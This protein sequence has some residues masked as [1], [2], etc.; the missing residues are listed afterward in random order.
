MLHPNYVPHQDIWLKTREYLRRPRENYG[1]DGYV[2][3]VWTWMTDE[4]PQM[5][6][7]DFTGNQ[8]DRLVSN[9]QIN[10]S[11]SYVG[12]RPFENIVLSRKPNQNI[13]R[14]GLSEYQQT[15]FEEIV[16]TLE[17]VDSITDYSIVPEPMETFIGFRSDDEGPMNSYLML[18]RRDYVTFTMST[19]NSDILYFSQV[20]DNNGKTLGQISLDVNSMNSF[21]YDSLGN[22]RGLNPGQWIKLYITD[23]TNTKNKYTSL[24]HGKIFRVNTVY[25]Q[26][27]LVD[28]IDT[29]NTESTKI[30]DY[31]NSGDITYLSVTFKTVDKPIGKFNVMG[32]TEIED[33]RYKIELSNVGHNIGPDDVYIFKSY[34]INEQVLIGVL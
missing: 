34:D 15:I 10:A 29:L 16:D 13:D 30:T 25:N 20:V 6:L 4:Y 5:F 21:V 1:N 14:V 26:I 2:D 9:G 28:F 19:Y 23:V 12:E 7:Y 24:N 27:L 18:Y 11:Y 3:L 33:I 22:K 32:Q 8:L 17:H 31:P